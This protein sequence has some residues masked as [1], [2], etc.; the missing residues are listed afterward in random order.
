MPEWQ[1]FIEKKNI[2][3]AV[4]LVKDAQTVF[5]RDDIFIFQGN[6]SPDSQESPE[7]SDKEDEDADNSDKLEMK[8]Y[9][10][11]LK[12]IFFE[13]KKKPDQ[14][15]SQSQSQ[16]QPQDELNK[17]RML[18]QYLSDSV[19][20][21]KIIH[22]SLPVVAQ[23][24]G[25]KQSSDI[26]EAIE[27]FVSAFEFGLLNAM[28]GVRRML[29][30]IWSQEKTIKDAV[31]AAYKRLYINVESNNQRSASAAIA[32]N[33]IALVVGA[34]LGEETSLEKLISEFVASKEIGKG[35]FQVL[36]EYFTGVMPHAN[37]E[38]SRAAIQILGMCALSEV[39][40]ITSNVQNI[41]DFGLSEKGMF[42]FRLASYSCQALLRMVPSK[43]SQED[44]N[45]PKKF[46][47]DHKLFKQ[48]E[49]ILVEGIEFKQDSHFMPMAKNALSLIFQL[50]ESPD[51]FISNIIRNICSRIKDKQETEG[52]EVGKVETFVLNRL[53]YIVGQVALCQV[54][55][56]S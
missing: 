27:F 24:L 4:S 32:Q 35:V 44:P 37:P 30:L 41:V 9:L 22:K 14:E 5:P 55:Q 56:L 34:T 28:I 43:L 39:T 47:S 11:I 6:A 48:L 45:S 3:R 17:Q 42:D 36:F 2:A 53:C 51:K 15:L 12:N 18:V 50:G 10:N 20:F 8:H 54:R 52:G 25:S 33:L 31:V 7:S 21:S 19:K 26:L 40:I 46:E 38:D 13:T 23:L 29:A 1:G 49:R 16:P